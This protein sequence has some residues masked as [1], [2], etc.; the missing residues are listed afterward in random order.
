MKIPC[1]LLVLLFSI[2]AYAQKE[3][4]QFKYVNS[5]GYPAGVLT[6]AN[7]AFR[8]DSFQ[9]IIKT[10]KN[11]I[12]QFIGSEKSGFVAIELGLDQYPGSKLLTYDGDIVT[13]EKSFK[14]DTIYY[15]TDTVI[16][17]F[18]CR[19]VGINYARGTVI[20]EKKNKVFISDTLYTIIW[21]STKFKSVTPFSFSS[22]KLSGLIL[23]FE[24]RT[25][26]PDN[27]FYITVT[28]DYIPHIA[29]DILDLPARCKIIKS[30]Q[31]YDAISA[32]ILEP[33]D[34]EY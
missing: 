32:S 17:G 28:S 23:R 8:F 34:V 10:K 3:I 24:R 26:H 12:Y 16:N 4:Y 9:S 21:V 11:R 30:I 18:T 20:D 5:N 13:G 14:I 27:L 1:A 25:K 15:K 31:E 19:K 29:P 7:N 33:I 2:N 6:I 22:K